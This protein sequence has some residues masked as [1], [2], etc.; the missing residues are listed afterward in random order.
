VRPQHSGESCPAAGSST[1]IADWAYDDKSRL[2][3]YRFSNGSSSASK[4]V[5][6]TSDPLDRPVK[7]V[8]TVSGQTTTYDFTS[9]GVTDALSKEVLTGSGATSKRYAYDVFGKRATITEGSNRYSSLYDPHT[10]VSLLIDQANQVKESYGSSAYGQTNA[11]LTKS[12]SGF[13]AKTNPYR[14]TGKR[15]DQGSSTYDMG[16]RRYSAATGRFLQVDLYYSALDNLGLSEDPRTQNRYA[17]AGA[18]PITFVEVDGHGVREVGRGLWRAA[19]ETGRFVRRAVKDPKKT[20]DELSLGIAYSIRHPRKATQAIGQDYRDA[21]QRGG[22]SEAV[23]YAVGSA[24]GAKGLGSVTRLGRGSRL[25]PDPVARGPHTV[26]KRDDTG[27]V[28][29][30]TTYS[31]P[32]DQRNPSQWEVRKRYDGDGK[33]HFNKVTQTKVPTPHVHTKRTPGG[34]R[35]AKRWETPGR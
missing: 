4:V 31:K 3:G 14:S 7:Q 25:Q 23:G 30:Y 9:V 34:V 18:N 1:L 28:T 33:A 13:N 5:D 11:A 15:L 32:R 16:A 24:V 6:D 2:L 35:P 21:H 27:K 26:F 20:I 22:L 8:E 10:S 29:K 19:K 17:L 12:A